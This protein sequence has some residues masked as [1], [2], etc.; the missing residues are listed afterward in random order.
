MGATSQL[1]VVPQFLTWQL[2]HLRTLWA[3]QDFPVTPPAGASP[4]VDPDLLTR[5]DF[6]NPA[7]NKAYA[8][9]L[10]RQA[11][12]QTWLAGLQTAAL[13]GLDAVLQTGIQKKSADLLNLDA[14]LQ[15]GQDISAQL[16][17]INL[18]FEAFDYLVRICN[19]APQGQQLLVS[20]WNDVFSI[21]IQAQKQA[22]YPAWLAAEQPAGLTLGPDFFIS[23]P[24]VPDPF[25]TG[26]DQTGSLL[27]AGSVDPQW[28]CTP[29]GKLQALRTY[30]T[31]TQPGVW[32]A[33]S[34]TSR[35]ISPQADEST[36]DPPGVYIYSTQ[37]DLTVYDP[38]TVELTVRVAVDNDLVA[39]K[40]NGQAVPGLSASGYTAFSSLPINDGF[41]PGTNTLLFFVNN[42]GNSQNPSGLRVEFSFISPP[43]PAAPDRWRAPA[44]ARAAWQSTVEGRTAQQQR[45]AEALQDA[46]LAAEEQTLPLL[47]DALVNA[48]T[49]YSPFAGL[50]STGVDTSGVPM[51]E[52]AAQSIWK[53]ISN[54]AGPSSL[55]AY[56]TQNR[57]GIWVP[58]TSTALWISPSA[59]EL[60]G[61]ARGPYTY[62]TDFQITGFVPA[63]ASLTA[64]ISASFLL[65]A[66]ILNGQVVNGLPHGI[67]YSRSVP[68]TITGLSGTNKLQ[69]GVENAD[70]TSGTS[71]L[72]TGIRVE[73]LPGPATVDQ[74]W[75]SQR[76]LID[77]NASPTQMTTRLTLAI[78]SLQG[79]FSGIRDSTF[80]QMSPQPEL[81]SWGINDLT[82]FD[83]YW[84]WASSYST[85]RATMLAF[86]YPE[87]LL[88][89]SLI[90]GSHWNPTQPFQTFIRNLH[91]NPSITIPGAVEQAANY[92]N[93]LKGGPDAQGNQSPSLLPNLPPSF[94][95]LDPR[96]QDLGN[97]RTITQR[98][99][100]PPPPAPPVDAATLTGYWEVFF[101]VPV[102]LALRLQ[103][104][105]EYE[106]ALDWYRTVYDI[107]QPLTQTGG[108]WSDDARKIFYGLVKERSAN[109]QFI[110]I[111]GPWPSIQA[112]PAW[113]LA[114]D[115]NPH[116]VAVTR[117]YPYTRFVLQSIVSCMLDLADT[118]F[119]RE[120]TESVSNARELYLECLSHL[121]ELEEITSPVPGLGVNP[122]IT[123]LRQRAE[124]NL[125]KM[126]SN[127]NIAGLL[128]Q[129]D[130]F[131]P[132]DE[133]TVPDRRSSLEPTQ[134]HYA[135][136][137][138][139]AKQLVTLA[140]QVETTYLG[141]LTSADNETYNLMK[142]R[143]DLNVAN[144]S[145]TLLADQ[146]TEALDGVTVA[147]DQAARAKDE[148]THYQDLI[149]AGYSEHEK[150]VL[151]EQLDQ[152]RFG[153]GASVASGIGAAA[154]GVATGAVIGTLIAPGLGTAI[155][156][157]IGGLV[158]GAGATS[159]G[160]ST[161]FGQHAQFTATEASYERRTQEW[162]YQLQ[163]A[164]D[165]IQTT[166]DQV[167]V[168][169]DHVTVVK[170]QKAIATI[171]QAN[172]QDVVN[173]LATKFTNADLYDWM[174]GVL[175]H[176]YRFYLQ[177]ATSVAR[178]AE[179]QLAF[180]RQQPAL[181]V[182]QPEYWIPLADLSAGGSTSSDRRGLTGAER[183]LADITQLDQNAFQT[184]RR[185][186]QL[187]KTISLS[188]LDPFAF[189]GFRETGVL[190][191]STSEHLFDQDFPGHYVRL[192]SAVRVS[193]VALVPPTVGIRATLS[194]KGL[195]RVVSGVPDFRQVI[196]QREVEQVGLSSP[197]NA[198]G[199]F[200]LDPQS[201]LLR[202]FE[203]LG[204]DTTWL[205]E[206]PKAA[207]PL[208]YNSIGDVLFSIDYTALYSASY[209][210]QVLQQ[211]DRSVSADLGYSFVQEF[212]D[213]WYDL[214]NAD[215][216]AT[217]VT[218]TFSTLPADFP[219]NV[220]GLIIAQ[221]VLYFARAD[222][223][224]LEVQ[225]SD[226]KFTPQG[227]TTPL[228]GGAAITENGVIST[229]RSN[230]SGWK[231]K[232]LPN[233]PKFLG[234]PP[235]GQWQLTLPNTAQTQAWF[236]NKQIEDILL[237]ITFGGTR[238]AWLN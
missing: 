227:A 129:F 73:F 160:L 93:D 208:D 33:N 145:V 70:G 107:D 30:A 139:R 182:I 24:R 63:N 72:P 132:E 52:G 214:N 111:P 125:A 37:L 178:L 172:A 232:F 191:F 229:R 198:T 164:N 122:Q 200:E 207:N 81:A 25:G 60:P 210:N 5:G 100:T 113:L 238:P 220:D 177:Q 15:S 102:Q 187:T 104:A 195:S 55:N 32:L 233:P 64:K 189:Q 11:Q 179:D 97:L 21:L 43:A 206:M 135:T 141:V 140:Q 13:S 47:R 2:Q 212:P 23:P 80:R 38:A 138:D 231:A 84:N 133:E 89:P 154:Q 62:E 18:S 151:S 222:G 194:N 44:G 165:D 228:D 50:C 137:I 22:Q 162:E 209:R 69:I 216:T 103:Q 215:P 54:P 142:A 91:T 78:G 68:I 58:N 86:L 153:I 114:E 74:G 116:D 119:T 59:S 92:L 159:S 186:L 157:F 7:T 4:L 41:L 10:T 49:R 110:R 192:I 106:A 171:Q 9:Y 66:I 3:A 175:G 45:L 211:L 76:L 123:T 29:P 16:A 174:S 35:W 6:V 46:V 134:Y 204:V 34:Q 61:D 42:L 236:A 19:L 83:G 169:N 94:G 131:G 144:A 166:S 88:N 203:N 152:F 126:R 163:L 27:S 237:V 230:G 40:L 156:A 26:V 87:N 130:L 1:S 201:Q 147:N 31:A 36:G 176:V 8:L 225:V 28:T 173:F 14:Q 196:V 193:V 218:V 161:G 136:L 217:T 67:G 168:A 108:Q 223:A 127:R 120:T 183:L 115:S 184:D 146:V 71:A 65:G 56:V 12:V 213:A 185:K 98:L 181:S 51:A 17:A 117:V 95:Y 39:V 75:L 167:T 85:W 101:F 105:G 99:L 190:V 48:A 96:D 188:Q 121:N 221:L 149:D 82:S 219:P 235:F 79:L 128:L 124:N 234:N 197:L 199:L 57:P 112:S 148:Q 118:Q 90:I 205:F 150:E 180:E 158:A 53:I 20:D 202:P 224:S 170:D 109:P 143:G 226:F 77:L 155:G